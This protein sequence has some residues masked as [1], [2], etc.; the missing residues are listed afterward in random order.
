MRDLV[1]LSTLHAIW[2]N[3]DS[4][5]IGRSLSEVLL[6]ILSV[7]FVY[8]RLNGR[9]DGSA[10]EAARTRY[11]SESTSRAHEIGQTLGPWLQFDTVDAPPWVPNPLGD[12]TVRLAVF[13]IGHGHDYGLLAAGCARTDFP[14]DT[15]RLLLGVAVN[16]TAGSLRRKD[17]EEELRKQSEWQRITLA[18]IG[19]AVMT[20]DAHGRVTSLNQVAASLTGWTQQDAAGQPLEDVF[21]IRNEQSRQTVENPVSKVLR[22]GRI[23]GLGNHT[24][25]IARDGTERPIDD[26]AAPIRGSAGEIIGVVLIFRDVTEQRHAEWELRQSEARKAAIL[27]TALDCIITCDHHGNIVD[28]NPAAERT[29]GFSRAQALGREMADLIISSFVARPASQGHGTQPRHG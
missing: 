14:T 12:G 19:D 27:A 26:S 17:A 24:V 7:D 6:R 21:C 25:L 16:Q 23:V 9:D 29:F 13:P 15:E 8:V 20:T 11:R 18:S 3:A 10:N 22:E 2:D 5:R 28:F 1:A 4:L